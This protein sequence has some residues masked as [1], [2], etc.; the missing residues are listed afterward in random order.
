MLVDAAIGLCLRQGYDNTT[1][2]QIAAAADVSPRT[3]SRYFAT[4]EAVVLTLLEDFSFAVAAEMD[5]LPRDMPVLRAM[6]AAH[7]EVLRQVSTGELAEVT[8]ERITHMLR[9]LNS[10]PT[11]Q[12]AAADFRPPQY[13]A[14]LA[15][16]LGVAPDDRTVL[17]MQTVWSAIISTACGDLVDDVDGRPLGPEVMTERLEETY[18]RFIDLVTPLCD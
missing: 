5:R 3:F 18:G 6:Y 7:I 10:T 9:V 14:N 2:E 1:V 17:L 12:A 8:P 16:R 11:L 15:D 13:T 4:K